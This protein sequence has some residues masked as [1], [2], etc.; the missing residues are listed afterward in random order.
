MLKKVGIVSLSSGILGE[1]MVKHE[2]DLGLKRLENLGLEVVTLP[3]TLRGLNY[4]REHPEARAAD[5][6]TAFADASVDMILCAIGG[7]DTYR[8]LPY[9]FETNQLQDVIQ[10]KVFLGFSDTTM[11]HLMLH[12]LGLKT[13]YG[14]SFLADICELDEEMLPYSL[15]YF[16]EL[17]E[18]GTISEITPSNLWYDERTDFSQKA[19][20]TKRQEHANHGFELLRGPSTFKGPILGGC[21]E[22]LYDIFDA[23]RYSDSVALCQEYELF[24]SVTDWKGKILLLETSEEKPNPNHYRKMLQRLKDTGIF[25]VISGVLAGKPM[26]ET[27][28]DAYKQV[29]LE[30]I[31]TDIP[32]LYNLN[33][34][35]ATPR[36]IVPLGVMA[37]VN[38]AQQIIRFET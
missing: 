4:L 35:H 11:N 33:V 26:D 32:I 14:Q 37:E 2:L 34:G 18:T 3:N 10:Q 24:P 29:L 31:D 7:D 38:A 23:S 16:K 5:L 27:Y 1:D 21:L 15:A 30:V 20:G 9:L 19:L 36:A 25:S 6:L 12:K 28:Y 22:S 17:I 8:L 13:F